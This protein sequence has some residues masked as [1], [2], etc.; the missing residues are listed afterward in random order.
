[1]LQLLP[2]LPLLLLHVLCS[3]RC[4]PAAAWPAARLLLRL[5][6]EH[7]HIAVLLLLLLLLLFTV[8]GAHLLQHGLAHVG[9]R[10]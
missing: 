10:E 6:S 7:L 8:Q 2:L 1:V 4:A 9:E 5:M 3:A